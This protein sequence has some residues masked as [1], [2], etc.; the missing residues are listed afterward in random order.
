[1]TNK[2]EQSL[3]DLLSAFEETRGAGP[4]NDEELAPNA[5]GGRLNEEFVPNEEEG[6]P[7]EDFTPNKE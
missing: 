7:N 3:E 2:S 6:W 4:P 1:L 5:E